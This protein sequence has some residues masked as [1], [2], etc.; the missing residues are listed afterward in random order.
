MSVS[1]TSI[2]EKTSARS[3][4]TTKNIAKIAILGAIAT[5]L[6]L[7]EFPLPFAPSFY[8]FDFSEIAVLLG[9][10]AM[11]PMAGV[12]IEALKIVLNLLFNGTI[13]MG[14]GELAN[15]LI[16]VSLCVPAA[17]I[18]KR[19]KTKKTA[20]I[21]MIVGT[22]CMAIAGAVLNYLVLIPAYVTLA[23]FPLDAILQMGAAV[24]PAINSLGTLII[25]SVVPF[26]LLKGAVISVI[27]GVLY[28]HVSPLLHR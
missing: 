23:N 21:G 16:G 13:T 5:I 18:Y 26:N 8:K 27:T 17:I 7:F 12:L 24:N 28:K 15:F 11:G 22:V 9:A 14:V 3:V 4:L 25:F 2:T 20:I 6:M 19:H 1:K 10:F